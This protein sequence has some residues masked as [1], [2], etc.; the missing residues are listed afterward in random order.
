MHTPTPH[1]FSGASRGG[2]TT[3]YPLIVE[4][5]Y[6]GLICSFCMSKIG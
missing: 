5:Q 3:Y 6:N 1:R 4:D 2:W